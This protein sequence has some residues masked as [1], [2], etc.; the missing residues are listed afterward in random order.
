MEPLLIPGNLLFSYI[1]LE[2]YIRDIYSIIENILMNTCHISYDYNDSKYEWNCIYL[3]KSIGCKFRIALYINI[4]FDN[5]TGTIVK[6]KNSH[7]LEF[8]K[9]SGDG[10]YLFYFYNKMKEIFVNMIDFDSV[11]NFRKSMMMKEKSSKQMIDDYNFVSLQE[12]DEQEKDV[13][14][15]LIDNLFKMSE[16]KD[17]D[18]Q[19]SLSKILSSIIRLRRYRT[20]LY[21]KN[22]IHFVCDIISHSES[23]WAPMHSIYILVNISQDYIDFYSI[24]IQ[25]KDLLEKLFDYAIDIKQYQGILR[26]YSIYIISNLCIKKAKET[27]DYFGKDRIISWL[28]KI[29]KIVDKYIDVYIENMKYSIKDTLFENEN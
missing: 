23:E 19:C 20:F 29:D 6:K 4:F 9:I 25:K 16:N 7:V 3:N 2:L 22:F 26:R 8:E 28:L 17:P 15:K 13:Q 10:S 24:V 21:E 12:Y 5:K 18:V 27:I 1:V 14:E 11:H